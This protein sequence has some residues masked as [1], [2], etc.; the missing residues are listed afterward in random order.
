[1]REVVGVGSLFDWRRLLVVR[2]E[3]R[4]FIDETFILHLHTFTTTTSR[5]FHTNS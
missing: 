5:L 1:M 4:L 2:S 3:S